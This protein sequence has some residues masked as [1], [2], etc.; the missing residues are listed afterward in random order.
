MHPT[1][2]MTVVRAANESMLMGM[3]SAERH[4]TSAATYFGRAQSAVERGLFGIRE[5]ARGYWL[6]ARCLPSHAGRMKR[7]RPVQLLLVIACAAFLMGVGARYWRSS[8]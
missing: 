7:T 3:H 4:F 5:S 6:S 8:H 1:L 2:P